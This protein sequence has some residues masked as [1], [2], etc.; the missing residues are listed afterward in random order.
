MQ[1]LT[2]ILAIAAYPKVCPITSTSKLGLTLLFKA[3]VTRETSGNIH[4]RKF[5]VANN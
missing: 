1:A 4:E 2:R 3:F 5:I